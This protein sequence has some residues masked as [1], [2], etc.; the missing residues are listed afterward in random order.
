MLSASFSSI[1]RSRNLI[2]E[3]PK[4]LMVSCCNSFK[5]VANFVFSS[6]GRLS[7]QWSLAP[8]QDGNLPELSPW[9]M[10]SLRLAYRSRLVKILSI[11]MIEG[12]KDWQAEKKMS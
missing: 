9:E 12:D 1:E 3:L 6:L 5:N 2:T 4:E 8:N 11:L 10:L 7:S